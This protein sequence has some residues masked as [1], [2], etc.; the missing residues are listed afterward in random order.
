MKSTQVAATNPTN[1]A[2]QIRCNNMTLSWP[3]DRTGW[4]L[5]TQTNNLGQGQLG[6]CRQLHRQR[7]C[8][9]SNDLSVI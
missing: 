9:L 2:D 6:G 4:R 5:Q 3:A 7:Q 1:I 8:L